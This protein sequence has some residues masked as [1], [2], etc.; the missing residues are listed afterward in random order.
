L[1]R[2]DATDEEIE[3][4]AKNANAHTFIMNTANKYDTLVGERY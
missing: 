3:Q 1:G 4:A 2:L